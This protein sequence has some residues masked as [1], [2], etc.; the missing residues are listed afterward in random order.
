M[1][2]NGTIW[3]QIIFLQESKSRKCKN[4]D[5]RKESHRR[6][7]HEAVVGIPKIGVNLLTAQTDATLHVA[8]VVGL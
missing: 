2:K 8:A 5:Q 4:D 7:G 6:C 3:W 1:R